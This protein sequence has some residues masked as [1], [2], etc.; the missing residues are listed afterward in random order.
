M[1]SVLATGSG[2]NCYVLEE[3]GKLLLIDLGIKLQDIK[4]GIKYKVSDIVMAF[5][6]HVHADHSKSESKLRNMGVKVFAPYH[7]EN[8][9]QVFK[10]QGYY[11]KSFPLPHGDCPNAGVYI[12]SPKGHKLV[13]ATDFQRIDYRFTKLGINTFLI[14]CNHMDDIDKEANEGK[15]AH[16]IRD[17]SSLSVVKEFLKVNKTDKLQNVILCHLSP[18]NAQ[19]DMMLKEVREVVGDNVQCHIAKKGLVLDLDE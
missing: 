8:L 11:I 9:M 17:H 14:A 15:F 3:N 2:G 12:M 18:D 19:P 4:K 7:S 5:V 1:L 16:T 6:S 10:H 13:Y